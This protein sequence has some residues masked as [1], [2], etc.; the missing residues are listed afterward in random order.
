MGVG[1]V[2]SIELGVSNPVG[3]EGSTKVVLFVP[4]NHIR[5]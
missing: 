2:G 4:I 3:E 1:G 5:S